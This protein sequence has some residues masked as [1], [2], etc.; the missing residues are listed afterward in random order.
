MRK[1]RN[2]GGLINRMH[3]GQVTKHKC[4]VDVCEKMRVTVDVAESNI[5]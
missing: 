5:I 2:A 1:I 3:L 4:G